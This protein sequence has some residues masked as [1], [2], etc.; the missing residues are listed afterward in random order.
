MKGARIWRAIY[1]FKACVGLIAL[2]FGTPVLAGELFLQST[3]STQ[4]SGLYDAILPEFT[5]AYETEVRVVAVGTGQAIKNTE[6]CDGDVL[7]VHARDAEDEFVRNGFGIARHDV[8]ENDFVLVGPSGDPAGISGMDIG[9]ALRRIA[10]RQ[11]TFVSRGD[12]SGTHKKEQTIWSLSAFDPSEASG[13]WYREAGAG[14][15]ATLNIAVG[16]DAYTLV[17]RATWN[18][19][20]NRSSHK[21]LVEGSSDLRNPYGV[22]AVHPDHCPLAN[23]DAAADFIDWITGADGQAAIAAFRPNG[24]QLFFPTAP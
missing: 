14:M 22:I 6:N 13:T 21:V 20:A 19:F 16:M 17:D 9:P 18:T 8:M 12:D 7:L 5:S 2:S 15:G 24:E 4:N 3:T 1:L 10:Q 11:S 23:H